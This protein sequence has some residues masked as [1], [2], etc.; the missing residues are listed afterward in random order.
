MGTGRDAG[1]GVV[2]ARVTALD[3]MQLCRWTGSDEPAGY[4]VTDYFDLP[5]S[6]VFASMDEALAALR[7][8]YRGPDCDGV[9]LDI[10]ETAS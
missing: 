8:T 6:Q 3:A 4:F 2:S 7:R 9:G 1:G 10:P 5:R